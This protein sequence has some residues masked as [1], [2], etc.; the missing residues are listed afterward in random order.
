MKIEKIQINGFGKFEN[1]N[2]ELNDGINIIVGKN[3]SGKSTLLKFINSMLYGISK[4]KRGKNISDLE[5]YKPWNAE[6][7][8]GK[9][10]YKLDDNNEFEIYRNFKNKEL[11]IYNNFGDDITPLFNVEKNKVI[12][13][14]EQ[15][16]NT[17]ILEM[18]AFKSKKLKM[19]DKLTFIRK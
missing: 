18:P 19:Y 12:V 1:K 8:S 6:K 10:K 15:L 14:K 16:K 4:N 3:E 9:I 17:N 7:Y 2:I 13:I 11:K 5:K